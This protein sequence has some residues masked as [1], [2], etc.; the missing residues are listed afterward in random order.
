MA[1]LFGHSVLADLLSDAGGECDPAGTAEEQ[2]PEGAGSEHAPELDGERDL[3]SLD[4]P[5]DE[6]TGDWRGEFGDSV[7]IS[8]W[9]TL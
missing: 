3:G 1:T 9:R 2:L 5:D 6:F 8:S 4:L 7:G